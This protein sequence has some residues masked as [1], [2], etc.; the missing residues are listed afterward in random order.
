MS[1]LSL[2]QQAWR[3]FG[4]ATPAGAPFNEL[5]NRWC[6]PHRQYHTLHHLGEC[7]ALLADS[8]HECAH[9]EEVELALWFHDAVFDPEFTD[10]ERRSADLARSYTVQA[11][12]PE[13]RAERIHALVMATHHR[14]RPT[15]DARVMVDIDQAIFGAKPLRFREYDQQI[16][17]EFAH[18][19][20]YLYR[21]KRK[22]WLARILE[23]SR[24]YST[25]RFY[26]AF[27]RSARENISLAIA[28]LT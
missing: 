18:I 11:G 22:R 23:R 14:M 9:P 27:E 16:R 28:G 2:W 19:P 3:P 25:E 21:V 7:L 26:K 6:E 20:E 24:V 1:T 4:V 15:G 5:L 17:Q 12:L 13:E 8:R 10:N